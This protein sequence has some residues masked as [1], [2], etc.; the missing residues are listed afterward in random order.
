MLI[1]CRHWSLSSVM[2]SHI[3]PCSPK[4][5]R[6]TTLVLFADRHRVTSRRYEHLIRDSIPIRATLKNQQSI[7]YYA[8]RIKARRYLARSKCV[9]WLK[10]NVSFRDNTDNSCLV[11]I[12]MSSRTRERTPRWLLNANSLRPR[13]RIYWRFTV[14]T[15]GA[16]FSIG[17]SLI[18]DPA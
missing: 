12:S 10:I 2:Y 6:Q 9:N 3:L 7:I 15:E 5:E 8:K 17:V 18:E 1:I 13:V 11:N 16:C 4:T 14:C